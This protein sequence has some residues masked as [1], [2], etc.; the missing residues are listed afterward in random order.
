MVRL[1]HFLLIGFVLMCAL[2]S[3]QMKWYGE[4]IWKSFL[5]SIAIVITGLFSCK[6]WFFL[7]NGYWGARSFYGA[8]FFAPLTFFLVSKL[9]KIP[10]LHSLD[11][12]A[13]AGCLILAVLKVDCMIGGCCKGITLYVKQ[14]GNSVRFP[15]Q[16]GEFV[17]ALIL[18]AYLLMKSKKIENRG[19]IYP[20]ALVLYGA[21]R[22]VLNL[23][24][25]DWGR[26]KELKLLIPLGCIWSCIAIIVGAIWLAI[27]K[28]KH[29]I[30][31]IISRSSGLIV[32]PGGGQKKK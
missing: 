5:V 16:A 25:D 28:R 12:C 9:L 21:Q 26:T 23:L 8:I 32:P 1:E 7:E 14:N 13:T 30:K 17:L 22:F 3:I 19:K 29:F 20:L 31:R 2:I 4:K 15:S 18:S 10:Y 11:Y 27:P 24:R 6:L